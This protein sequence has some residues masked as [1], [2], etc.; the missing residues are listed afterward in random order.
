M[1]QDRRIDLVRFDPGAGDRLGLQRRRENQ[2]RVP[3]LDELVERH[4]VPGGFAGKARVRRLLSEV[5]AQG[6]GVIAQIPLLEDLPLRIHLGHV[7][8]LLVEINSQYTRPWLHLLDQ[9]VLCDP[10]WVSTSASD[11]IR[12]V[13]PYGDRRPHRVGAA[14][15]ML[16]GLA[17]QQAR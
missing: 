5:A 4:P 6:V 15:F 2:I 1:G 14:V 8:G 16:S 12:S 11:D 7:R 3:R 13:V 10:P 17:L 9:W